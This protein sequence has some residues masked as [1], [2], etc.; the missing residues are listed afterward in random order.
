MSKGLHIA[1]FI[2]GIIG[3]LCASAA[4][5]LSVVGLSREH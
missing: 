4:V 5:V 3:T 2:I 1:E